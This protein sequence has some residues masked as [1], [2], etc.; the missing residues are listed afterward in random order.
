MER[1]SLGTL[2]GEGAFARVYS[3]TA[4]ES[5][6]LVAIKVPRAEVPFGSQ[7]LRAE[8]RARLGMHHA[9][10][11]AVRELVDTPTG[12]VL[13]MEHVHGVPL[14]QLKNETVDPSM[15]EAIAFSALSG[16]LALHE[17]SLVHGDVKPANIMVRPDGTSVI[18]DFDLSGPAVPTNPMEQSLGTLVYAAPELLLGQPR[19]P[20]TD[21]FSLGL[22][23]LE[24][25]LG[26]HPGWRRGMPG[27]R[28]LELPT[29]DN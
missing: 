20:A 3:G 18:I 13:I 2:L 5:R 16:L 7:I 12:A 15:V 14:S 10:L 19:T 9:N 26:R 1:Y 8:F 29:D 17:N 28:Q 4:V 21:L 11:V 24:L 23:L 22:V 25:L 27:Q 6:E